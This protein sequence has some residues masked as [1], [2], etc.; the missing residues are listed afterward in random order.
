MIVRHVSIKRFRGIKTLD[1]APD[2]SF[3]CLI[4]PGDSMKTTILDAVEMALSPRW[5]LSFDDY[6]FYNADTS[7]PIEIVLTVGD[8]PPRLMSE[9]KYGL[10]LRGWNQKTGLHDEPNEEGDEPVISIRLSVDESL[11]PSWTVVNDRLK[12]GIPVSARDREALGVVR[13]AHTVDRHLT[14]ARGSVLSR[15]T[16]AAD[17]VALVLAQVSRAARQRFDTSL[18][19][20][21]TEAAGRLDGIGKLVGVRSRSGYHPGLDFASV[22]SFSGIISLM[23]GKIPFSQAGLGSRKLLA[24]AIEHHMLQQ[25]S[26]TLIDEIETGLEPHR[27][28]RLL[29]FLRPSQNGRFKSGQVIM[30]THSPVVIEELRANELR[31]VRVRD[32]VVEIKRCDRTLQGTLRACSEAFL[33]RHVIVCEGATE[34]GLCRALD[35]YWVEH[36][37]SEPFSCKGVVVADGNGEQAASRA[38]SYHELGYRTALFIDSDKKE[39]LDRGLDLEK[40][41]VKLFTWDGN[42]S[43][44][45]RVFNDLPWNEVICLLKVVRESQHGLSDQVAARMPSSASKL[46][47]DPSQWS[48]TREIRNAIGKAAKKKCWFKR[49]DLGE[50]LG[51]AVARSLRSIGRTELARTIQALKAWVTEG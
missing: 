44:E 14:W 24:L 12:E 40:Q 47:N 39:N 29:R 9:R 5:N 31:V 43:T 8:L 7:E 33:G 17:E 21:L 1:W 22:G 48:D 42:M 51:L 18:A 41:G 16:G 50:K 49:I 15:F 38:K 27:L 6:D 37:G 26:I 11:K 36:D 45:E 35:D 30:T 3:V 23:D 4:G 2:G 10:H 46:P 19:P 25:G 28:R 20:K 32:G 34:V 13:L